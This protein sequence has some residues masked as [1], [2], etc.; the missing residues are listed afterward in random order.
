M[1]ELGHRLGCRRQLSL[2]RRNLRAKV[3][4]RRWKWGRRKWGSEG[5]ER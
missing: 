3:R 2:E 4:V 1:P 5:D